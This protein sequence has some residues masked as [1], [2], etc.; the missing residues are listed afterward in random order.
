MGRIIKTVDL[1]D[2]QAS[3]ALGAN[4]ADC[5]RIGDV[6][7]LSGELGVGKTSLARG[8]IRALS[9]DKD[10]PSP[11]YSLLQT[12]DTR[13]FEIWHFDLYRL[14]HES[15][16][17][18]LGIED[19]LDTGVCIIEWPERISSLLSG[20]ELTVKLSFAAKGRQAAFQGD[21]NW[22]ARLDHG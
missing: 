19:A 9:G 15:E 16:V 6:V 4:I 5:L 20:A 13:K 1:P 18:R 21:Q 7:L 12:Y 2:E 22:E 17:W 14:E 3:L 10:I 11:T 8:L